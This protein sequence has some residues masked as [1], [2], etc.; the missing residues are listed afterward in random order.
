M[1]THKIKPGECISSLAERMW[2]PVDMIWN[3]PGNASLREAGR[4]PNV[5]APG[6]EVSLPQPGPRTFEVAVDG[7]HCFRV[8]RPRA[9]FRL[10]LQR[11]GEPLDGEPYVLLVGGQELQGTADGEGVRERGNGSRSGRPIGSLTG[12]AKRIAVGTPKR[13]GGRAAVF[14]SV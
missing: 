13:I 14:G 11:N 9:M 7:A 6:D 8:K 2:L 3:D 1:P 12:T 4:D 10:R 5:L